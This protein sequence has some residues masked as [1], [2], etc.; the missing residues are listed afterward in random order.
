MRRNLVLVSVA[1]GLSLM[2][3][4]PSANALG[5]ASAAAPVHSGPAPGA[6]LLVPTTGPR[7]GKAPNDY[8]GYFE[9][10]VGGLTLTSTVTVPTMKCTNSATW[11]AEVGLLG[12][13]ES[14]NNEVGGGVEVGC[15]SV[16][17]APS[18]AAAV[19]DPTL[20]ATCGTLANP[21]F[22]GDIVAVTVNASGGCKPGC[23]SFVVTLRDATRGWTESPW[24]GSTTS[25]DFD[26]FIA[27]VGF[28]PLADFGKVR[29]TDVSVNGTGWQRSNI[30]DD[31]FH[32]LARTSGLT[33]DRTSFTVKWVRT[34]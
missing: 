15:A 33:H 3:V 23:S 2:L 24:S 22:P 8:A 11:G 12:V 27:A 32:T 14:G 4:A 18:Y 6:A 17:G 34:T 1:T 9:N 13:V 31:A 5:A 26:T 21:V 10:V 30:V 16:T 28:S 19:C 29:L 25:S 20:T 7:G